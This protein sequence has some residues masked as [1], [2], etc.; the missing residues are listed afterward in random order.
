[1]AR[2]EKESIEYLKLK[3][4]LINKKKSKRKAII[5]KEK[6]NRGR[7]PIYD[8]ADDVKN[9]NG[10]F[11]FDDYVYFCNLAYT[12]R[13]SQIVLANK[14]FTDL[15]EYLRDT[16]NTIDTMFLRGI[17]K[18]GN[19]DSCVK[20]NIRLYKDIHEE[21]DTLRK[22]SKRTIAD[23]F[24]CAVELFRH[25]NP[26]FEIMENPRININDFKIVPMKGNFRTK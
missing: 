17:G 22:T 21:Y 20:K 8:S 14:L 25:N 11:Y 1:M 2:N 15:F 18:E 24:N 19:K 5:A 13:Y 9:V 3:Q 4:K 23:I 7:K 6:D 16:N 26:D 10:F 12:L